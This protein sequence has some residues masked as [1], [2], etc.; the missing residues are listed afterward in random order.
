[1]YFAP[2]YNVVQPTREHRARG[3]KLQTAFAARAHW[4]PAS[5]ATSLYIEN[6]ICIITRRL[7]LRR[8]LSAST[9]RSS[10]RHLHLR[11]SSHR[12]LHLRTSRTISASLRGDSESPEVAAVVTMPS[13]DAVG[14]IQLRPDMLIEKTVPSDRRRLPG[15][16]FQILANKDVYHDEKPPAPPPASP[17]PAP[18]PAPP[19]APRP[20]RSLAIPK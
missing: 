15:R 8:R 3:R 16:P 17:A 10:H 11:T 1:M 4:S 5:T 18:P 6:D 12:H 9:A 2:A 19:L 13:D 20:A 14:T 7:R